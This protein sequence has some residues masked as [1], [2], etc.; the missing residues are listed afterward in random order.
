MARVRR[1]RPPQ[2]V[3]GVGASAGG[4]EALLQLVAAIPADS[5][6]AIVVLQH[7][8]PSQRGKLAHALT[9]ATTLP[10]EDA[11]DGHRVRPNT[12]VVVP[13]RTSATLERGTLVLRVAKA[14]ARPRLP[15]DALFVS[16][17]AALGARAVGVV[18][19]GSA[20]DG[21][22]G[23]RAIRNAG[24]LAIAQEPST[25][26]FDEMPRNAIA[27]GVAELVLPPA[28]IAVR[29]GELGDEP[30]R[31]EAEQKA[32]AISQVLEHLREASGIDFTSYKRS[33]IERRLAR[34]LGKP[35][36]ASLDDYA[37][38]LAA[39]PEDAR[40]L[41]EDL[42]I[43]VT[44]FFRDAEVLDATAACVAD[45]ARQREA[46][47]PV[48]VWVPGC[49]TG[50]EVYSLAI[51]LIERLGEQQPLHLFGTDLSER[52]V[53]VARRGHYPSGIERQVSPERLARFFRRDEHGYRIRQEV[54]ERCVFVRHDLVTDPPFSRLD[55]VSCRNVLIYLGPELQKRVIPIFHY[56]LAQPGFL[57]LGQAESIAGW[58]GL[59]VQFDAAARIFARKP[60]T[61]TAI[62][63]PTATQLGRLP[64]RLDDPTRGRLDVQREVDQMLLAR[65]APACV[66]VDSQLD[67]VQFR[68]RTGAYLEQASG[69]P[70]LNV[71]RM[72]REELSGEL[73]L[74]LQRAQRSGEPAS[75]RGIRLRERGHVRRVDVEVIPVR[76]ASEADRHFAIVFEEAPSG[77]PTPA[78][79][80]R[81]ARHGRGDGEVERLRQELD[82]TKEYLRSTIAQHSAA[83]EELGIVN[84]E[85]QSTNEE[86]Q[87]TNEELQTAKEELQSTNEELETVNDE[88]QRGNTLL[89]EANDDLVNV[90]ASVD[91]AIIIVDTERRVRRF[92]PKARAVLRLIPG[93]LGRP[94]EDLQPRVPVPGLDVAIARVIDTLEIH[95]SEVRDPDGATLRMQIRPYRTA[96]HQIA[97]AVISFVDVTQLRRGVEEAQAA[98]DFAA[99]IVQTVPT[100]L[101]VL[102]RELRVH[103]ANHAFVSAFDDTGDPAGR[104]LLAL[105]EW[106]T[107]DLRGRLHQVVD[108]GMSFENVEVE[109]VAHGE[110]RV[111]AI[112][113]TPIAQPDGSRLV[114]VGMADLT[115]RKRLEQA[116]L[117]AEHERDAFLSAVSHELRT[118]LSAIL[119]W[120]EVL[121]DLERSD[122]R[123]ITALETIR[124][125]AASEARLVDDLLDLSR[126]RDG[127]LA[128]TSE[129]IE[130]ATV[131]RAAID[132]VRATAD[133]K[134]ISLAVDVASG[135]M[136]T[137]DSRR[138]LHVVMKLL[139]NAVK[140]TPAGGTVHVTLAR[141]DHE[142]AL[143]VSDDGQGIPA[144]FLPRLFEPFAREDS[145]TTRAQR[146]LG[147]GLALVR[148]F[149][150]RQRGTIEV[151]SAEGQGTSFTVRFPVTDPAA[152]S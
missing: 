17:A 122:P 109:H 44:E 15:I 12:I 152:S 83:N 79:P 116:R 23:L 65:Y 90:L 142:V 103:S 7:L 71:V 3:V 64:R 58:D 42:L 143:R 52:S 86:L 8:P 101:V 14:G 81:L 82:A 107:G 121:R 132:A 78:A 40:T 68:G 21:T 57:V 88:L 66:V 69:Q 31:R 131:I 151:E 93:D 134:H 19:S 129:V 117:G 61:R 33:T 133:E 76:A 150:D 16:L 24:G 62:T 25:A 70:Q 92:T 59:F 126:S 113:G 135:T 94:V 106:R 120:A 9:A 146:G 6:V 85:L 38:F 37:A 30:P 27:G 112:A 53:D 141:A 118:P 48:R 80:K 100:P 5:G 22:A 32:T 56:A 119:L 138:L 43:H 110:A 11:V 75:T 91:I 125:S 127:E 99:T 29:L 123:W 34:R 139:S 95:E 98:R 26:R 96:E 97:G 1:S 51:L 149:V 105:G 115:D 104:L 108:H 50:E 35:G 55:L 145:S 147:I 128:V 148:H 20:N 73:R 13:P 60:A 4:L 137:A 47:T 144:A 10:V 49:S 18:L 67:V 2:R 28:A 130:P 84:E 140:F 41:Y 45:L 74:L 136:I 124:Q 63:F 89:R 87:S 102:D 36:L 46:N 54:R 72:T 39:H 77:P 114:L 111:F